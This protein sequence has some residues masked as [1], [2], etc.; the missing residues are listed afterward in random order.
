MGR[1]KAGIVHAGET[2]LERTVRLLEAELPR[3]FV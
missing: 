1:D 2:L 3:V